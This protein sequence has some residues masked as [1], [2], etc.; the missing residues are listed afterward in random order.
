MTRAGIAA[1]V[2]VSKPT[3]S[4]VFAEL[5]DDG[6]IRQIG[7]AQGPRGPRAA[8]FELNHR[9]AWVVGLDVGRRWVRASI[10]DLSGRIVA[11]N[12]EPTDTRSH[13]ALLH[14][15]GRLAHEVAERHEVAWDDVA[16]VTI[17]SPG[18][19]APM[20]D[21]VLLAPNLPDW[22]RAGLLASL[23][24]RLGEDVDLENDVNL[25][26]LAELWEGHGRGCRDFVYLWIGTGVGV[27]L[28]L[29]GALHRGAHG[30]AGEVAYLPLA[31]EPLDPL[32]ADRRG[33]FE[34]AVAGDA[35]VRLAAAAGL[36]VGSPEAVFELARDGDARA[37][38]VV[39]QE[40]RTLALGLGAIV[41]IVDPELVIV[42]G[43]LGHNCSVMLEPLR[44]ELA[45]I[46]PFTPELVTSGL[47]SD[48][49]LRGAVGSALDAGW[50][51]VLTTGGP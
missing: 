39:E 21:A 19:P 4:D 44:R 8:L 14:Q 15:I 34:T 42:G 26:A 11:R 17:G 5:L 45:R 3:I 25:A 23:R 29:D 30:M 22:D 18:V 49:V 40:A 6:L 28:I 16:H 10:A 27:G 32:E 7:H 46:S 43:G 20:S 1:V 33:R 24:E 12:D 47:G 2:D 13:D 38:D 9:A 31:R 35:V 36:E 50:D 48:A 41:P 37:L 51:H